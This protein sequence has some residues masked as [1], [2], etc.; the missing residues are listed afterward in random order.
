MPNLSFILSL[1]CLCLLF[2]LPAIA[3]DHDQITWANSLA[4][5]KAV[6][7][8]LASQHGMASEQLSLDTT[9]PAKAV[10]MGKDPT[11]T[12]TLA[13]CL[14]MMKT[15]R[16]DKELFLDVPTLEVYTAVVAELKGD[17]KKWVTLNM[18][19]FQGPNGDNV[20]ITPA[21]VNGHI[22]DGIKKCVGMTSGEGNQTGYNAATLNDV[23][24]A[25]RNF[26]WTDVWILFDVYHV[27]KTED[28]EAAML[29]HLVKDHLPD[30]IYF[31]SS[32]KQ[33]D[34]QID[35]FVAH[36]FTT[37]LKGTY[38]NVPDAFR[39]KLFKEIES[40]TIPPTTV[41]TTET[42][43]GGILGQMKMIMGFGVLFTML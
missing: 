19:V 42:S 13:K 33:K 25:W 40:I 26:N 14:E 11:N 7:D 22:K 30:R 3:E 15:G 12:F 31:M 39:K 35:V 2:T 29:H 23:E 32:E 17:A 41:S 21:E 10:K 43:G 38:F 28:R 16:K 4:T 9:D 27:S 6:T 8:F 1:L 36:L 20:T 37:D 5:E 34:V 24:T 18:R